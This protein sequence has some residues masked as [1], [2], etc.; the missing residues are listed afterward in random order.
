MSL[1]IANSFFRTAS[2]Y[3]SKIAATRAYSKSGVGTNDR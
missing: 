3:A 1:R 2:G